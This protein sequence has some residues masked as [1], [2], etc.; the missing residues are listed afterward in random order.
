ML[1]NRFASHRN[2]H[3][4]LAAGTRPAVEALERRALLS[5]EFGAAFALG[6]MDGAEGHDI[7]VDTIGNV[8]VAGMFAGTMD[9]D[10]APDGE[11]LLHSDGG[12]GDGF[13][14]KYDPAGALVWAR[15]MG[16]AGYDEARGVA[17]DTLGNVYITGS[18]EGDALGD[19]TTAHFGEH[20]L[21]GT[22]WADVFVTKLDANGTFLWADGL[23]GITSSGGGFDIAL[24]DAGNVFTTG[25]VNLDW[26]FNTIF[27]M[28]HD[29]NGQREWFHRIGG[30]NADGFAIAVDGAGNSFITGHYVGTVDFDPGSGTFLLKSISYKSKGWTY[31]T[32]DAYVLALDPSGNFRWAGSMGSTGDD[33]GLGI[34]LD[35]AGNLHVTGQFGAGLFDGKNPPVSGSDFDPG[36]GTLSLSNAGSMDIF[37]V[38]LTG[39]GDLIWGRS[40]GGPGWD[41]GTDVAVDSA[42][43][44]YLTGGFGYSAGSSADM[45]PGS[46]TYTLSSAGSTDIFVSKLDSAGNF[47]WAAG[48]GGANGESGQRIALDNSGG[49]YTIGSFEGQV[50]FDPSSGTHYLA[51]TSSWKDAFVSKLVQIE[52]PPQPPALSINDVVITEGN[53]GAKT[54]TFTVTRSGDLSQSV[55][56]DYATADGSAKAGSDYLATAGTLTF[57][58][59]Q[60]TMIITVAILGDTMYEPDEVFYL[61]LFNVSP[62]ASLA[63]AVGAATIKNDDSKGGKK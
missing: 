61:N 40:M 54:A 15:Q 14:A 34:A 45:D 55:T 20:T 36:S 31:T 44:V 42:G 19:G 24:D 53:T 59:G 12:F 28:K 10:P 41:Y 6:G 23:S 17:V 4:R 49:V 47:V 3:L 32:A 58:A 27:A 37:A 52:L 29:T 62:N 11:V 21:G 22:G 63:D 51:S 1:N 43:D 46:G 2:R 13:V 50:D 56:V 48:M 18:Y 16:G 5:A 26:P 25:S 39:G 38:K 35:G 57:A 7:A 9:A 33:Q 60:T 30:S 8:Y